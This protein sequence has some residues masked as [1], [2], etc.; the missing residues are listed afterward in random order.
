MGATIAYM[1][2]LH[3]YDLCFPSYTHPSHRMYMHG[4]AFRGNPRPSV[5]FNSSLRRR[6]QFASNIS[7]GFSFVD[8]VSVPIS[9]NIKQNNMLAFANR[10]EL[11]KQY[12]TSSKYSGVQRHNMMLV[13]QLF[14]LLHSHQDV[15]MAYYFRSENQTEPPSL[16]DRRSL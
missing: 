10:P 12:T 9:D 7:K 3:C 1:L 6:T 14:L 15:N 8:K 11:M 5:V 4:L 13:A 16:A 2:Q